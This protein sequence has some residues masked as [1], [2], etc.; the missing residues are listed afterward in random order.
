MWEIEGGT[1]ERSL[2]ED[3]GRHIIGIPCSRKRLIHVSEQLTLGVQLVLR[4]AVLASATPSHT[5]PSVLV[6]FWKE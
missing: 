3:Q 1:R 6:V 5:L 4:Y 2:D